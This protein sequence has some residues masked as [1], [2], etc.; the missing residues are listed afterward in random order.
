MAASAFVAAA[1]YMPVPSSAG[2][3][4]EAGRKAAL[5]C[6][7]CHG[8]D[9]VGKV[10]GAP[11]ISGQAE[12]YLVKSMTDYKTGARKNDMMSVVMPPL[13]D[14]QIADLAAFYAAL[15]PKNQ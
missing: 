2:G 11:H 1:V 12:Q 7:A 3:N 6:Q 13:S 5:Q 15:P 14:Q 10:L 9:G 4:A 8:M